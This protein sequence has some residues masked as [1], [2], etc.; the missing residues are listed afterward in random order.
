MRCHQMLVLRLAYTVRACAQSERSK[1]LA[2]SHFCWLL[3]ELQGIEH[4][5]ITIMWV[6]NY[7][8]NYFDDCYPIASHT[9]FIDGLSKYMHRAETKCTANISVGVEIWKWMSVKRSQKQTRSNKKLSSGLAFI[10]T[11]EIW[12]LDGIKVTIRCQL[13]F[14]DV[15]HF[16]RIPYY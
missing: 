3:N 4:I 10:F 15:T 13:K 2:A 12:G 9:H 6:N 5:C 14:N 11:R 7:A 1:H 8:Q 16:Y